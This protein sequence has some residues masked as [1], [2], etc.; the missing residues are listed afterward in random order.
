MQVIESYHVDF[1]D[2]QFGFSQVAASTPLIF[3][4]PIAAI[5]PD[6]DV[7]PD[8]P[9]DMDAGEPDDDDDGEEDEEYYVDHIVASRMVNGQLQYLVKWTGFDLNLNTDWT[10]AE[11]LEE[12]EA[13][14][15]WL[16]VHHDGELVAPPVVPLAL[17][18]SVTA[19]NDPDIWLGL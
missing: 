8:V 1:D 15:R 2:N 4:L 13:L 7:V 19:A 10:D 5:V 16:E 11:N 9:A 3:E 6:A 14:D 12:T 18:N 17:A